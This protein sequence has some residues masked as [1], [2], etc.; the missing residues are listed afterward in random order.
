MIYAILSE[1]HFVSKEY[2]GLL[3]KVNAIHRTFYILGAMSVT[4]L[5]HEKLQV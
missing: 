3:A 2:R 5:C 1:N 4:S